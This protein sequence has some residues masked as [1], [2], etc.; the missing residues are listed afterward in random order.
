MND[1]TKMNWNHRGGC[2]CFLCP[3]KKIKIN[4]GDK[5]LAHDAFGCM[6]TGYVYDICIPDLYVK[7]DKILRPGSFWPDQSGRSRYM[8]LSDESDNDE[9]ANILGGTVDN[10]DGV[11]ISIP[12]APGHERLDKSESEWIIAVLENAND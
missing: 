7:V 1:I 10:Y 6:Y 5:V 4:V 8:R 9:L 12:D 2:R 3:N 11:Y